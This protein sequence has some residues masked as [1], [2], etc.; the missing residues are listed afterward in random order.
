MVLANLMGGGR[1]RAV[2]S[3][4]ISKSYVGVTD[5]DANYNTSALV[6]AIIELNTGN[7]AFTKIWE[8]T[9]PAGQQ[10]AWGHGRADLPRNQSF[11]WA[12]FIDAGTGFE[13]GTLRLQVSNARETKVL[14]IAEFDTR[15]LHTVTSTTLVTAQPTDIDSK[16]P[17]PFTGIWVNEDSRLQ[18][19]FKTSVQTTTVD[20]AGFAFGVTIRQ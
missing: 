1:R 19:M 10:I 12:A 7:S 18:L 2:D 4:V 20:Q 17:L 11:S 14:Y 5:G 3:R 15:E 9:V 16:Q 13:D 6:S 8:K